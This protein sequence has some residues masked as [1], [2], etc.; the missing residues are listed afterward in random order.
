MNIFTIKFSLLKK[1]KKNSFPSACL[2]PKKPF[3]YSSLCSCLIDYLSFFILFHI[4]LFIFIFFFS[5]ASTRVEGCGGV[6]FSGLW[7]NTDVEPIWFVCVV[8]LIPGEDIRSERHVKGLVTSR[9]LSPNDSFDKPHPSLC[10][11][12]SCAITFSLTPRFSLTFLWCVIHTTCRPTVE[13]IHSDKRYTH[14]FQYAHIPLVN[15]LK[16][17][18]PW[19]LIKTTFSRSR[20]SSQS[21]YN[22]YNVL[23]E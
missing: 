22:L 18:L 13:H 4:L 10:S 2:H 3:F 19:N 15:T 16:H 20:G 12:W 14:P 7:G 17:Q 8:L 23:Y 9:S 5:S 11:I 1:E 6:G 21:L